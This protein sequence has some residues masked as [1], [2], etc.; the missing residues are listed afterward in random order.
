ML[1]WEKR[2][3]HNS[4]RHMP[5]KYAIAHPGKIGDF[6]YCLPT[7]RALHER[8]GASIDMYTSEL[9]RPIETLVRY[10]SYVNDIIFPADYVINNLGQGVQPWNMSI[11]AG[12]DKV[13]QLGFEHFPQGPLHLFAAARAGVVNVPSP[14]YECPNTFFYSSPYI[15][16]AHCGS[17]THPTLRAAYKEFMQRCPIKCVQVGVEAD[18]IEDTPAE[19]KIGLDFLTTTSLISKASAFVG[20]YSGPLAIANGFPGLPKIITMWPGVGEQHG[21]HIPIT[22]DLI[23]ASADQILNAVMENI[24]I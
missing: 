23:H 11:P 5:L 20:F 4:G 6:L 2:A 12:Y 22:I 24:K 15:V 10:Q 18:F 7:A 13:F 3:F 14:M 21:L 1:A 16:V 19:N 8:D 17:R 9:C